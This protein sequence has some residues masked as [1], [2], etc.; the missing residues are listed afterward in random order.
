VQLSQELS[1]QLAALSRQAGATLFMTLLTTFVV[2]LARYSGQQ[3]ILVGTMVANR[4][5]HEV[6]PLIGF[7]SNLLVLR[8]QIEGRPTFWQLLQQIR[9]TVLTGFSH[10]DIP[11]EQLTTALKPNRSPSHTPWFQVLFMLQNFPMEYPNLPGLSVEPIVVE[12]SAKYDL[13]L[14]MTETVH[15]LKA[16]FAYN[17]DL[18]DPSTIQRLVGHFQVLLESFAN[19]PNQSIDSAP[20]LTA[21]ERHQLLVSWNQTQV[22][23]PQ[24]QGLHHLIEAQVERS[25]DAIAVVFE[26]QVLSYRQLN[27]RANQLA[28]YLR[29]LGVGPDRL[30]GICVERSLDMLIAMLAVLKAGGAYVPIDP[31][32][33]SERIQYVLEHAQAEVLLTQTQWL[34]HLQQIGS[35]LVVLDRDATHWAD[36]SSANLAHLTAPHHLAYVIYTS[37]STGKPKGVQLEHQGVVNFLKAMVQAPGVG[38]AD[39]VLA[40]TTLSFDIAVLELFAPLIVGAQVVI[41]SRETAADGYRLLQALQHHAIT[42]LQATP[43][44]WRLLLAA[45]WSGTPGLKMLCGGEA[46]PRELAEHLLA[47][48]GE[49]WNM[50]GPT[51][52]TV[53]SAVS[54]VLTAAS[55]ICIGA[56]IANTEFYVLDAQ[57][58]PVP[59]GVPGELYIGGDGLAR[60]YLH[61]PDLTAEKFVPHPW[62]EG[63]RLYRTGDRVRYRSDGRLEFL[64]RM[65]YQVK[66]RGFRIELGEIETTLSQ[67]PQLAQC[68]VM[69]RDE[70]SGDKRLVAYV[71]P[72]SGAAPTA[73]QLRHFL[74]QTLPD[75]M[76]PSAFVELATLPLT[77][78]GKVDRR[79]LPEPDRSQMALST[80]F[81]APRNSVEDQMVQIW[82]QLLQLDRVGIHDNFFELGG[83]SILAIQTISQIQT[84]LAVQLPLRHLFERPTIAQLAEHCATLQVVQ[85]LQMPRTWS[86]DEREEVEL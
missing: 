1:A 40:V 60:G 65:D 12:E 36:Q 72:V 35:K 38:P 4:D 45:N 79:Q 17:T 73:A 52:T 63:A 13:T 6:E 29:Q 8:T 11:F 27:Q 22:D 71:V 30:V 46:L 75:Y 14:T 76:L 57:Q 64:G 33:P 37:G 83:H 61:R 59:I 67:H 81:A 7:F 86:S 53:W 19:D 43:A 28:H 68:V 49:L 82:A 54:R 21:R 31:A 15:G 80:T 23:Y 24:D 58:Q 44:T 5:Y 32:Y 9:N 78:N 3:D 41:A 56:P 69:D 2:L 20:M 51:E 62:S 74:Q 16:D 34:S 10:K 47:R 50:Y 77:P 42:L 48:G 25:P 55:D 84:A 39:V 66:I 26:Q 70:P 18:F 85:R